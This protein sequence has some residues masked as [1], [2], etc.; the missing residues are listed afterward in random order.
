MLVL[1]LVLCWFREVIRAARARQTDD[2]FPAIL[3]RAR[4]ARTEEVSRIYTPVKL[5]STRF[6]DVILVGHTVFSSRCL[7]ADGIAL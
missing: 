2:Y 3:A 4:G 6:V 1:V 7:F 5:T